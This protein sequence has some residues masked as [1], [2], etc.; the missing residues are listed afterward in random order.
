M[1][2][3]EMV[4]GGMISSRRKTYRQALVDAR[5]RLFE[6]QQQGKISKEGR[7]A[8]L[9]ESFDYEMEGGPSAP[10]PPV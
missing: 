7:N 10:A 2:P 8:G 1:T 4:A 5:W 3:S 6:L 9:R